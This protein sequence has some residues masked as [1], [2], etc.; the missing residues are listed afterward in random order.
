MNMFSLLNELFRCPFGKE[1][2]LGGQVL[3]ICGVVI[4]GPAAFMDRN[5]GVM[6]I[7]L[8]RS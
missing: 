8:D 2:V 3:F 6:I 5:L 1:A 4:F 7:D